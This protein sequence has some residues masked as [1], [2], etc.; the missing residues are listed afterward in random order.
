MFIHPSHHAAFFL[1]TF[2]R[3]VDWRFKKNVRRFVVDPP[4]LGWVGERRFMELNLGGFA[5]ERTQEGYCGIDDRDN[6]HFI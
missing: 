1:P 4:L 6:P 3:T 5:L 2:V